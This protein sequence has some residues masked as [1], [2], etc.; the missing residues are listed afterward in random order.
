M[1]KNE[2]RIS[3]IIPTYNRAEILITSLKALEK[4]LNK[5]KDEIIIVDDGSNKEQQELVKKYVLGK[6]VCCY[7]Y[8]K[9]EGPAAARNIAV[10]KAKGD[11][12]IFLN[13]DSIVKDDFI[14]LQINFHQKHKENEALIGRFEELPSLVNTPIMKWLVSE[15]Q[16]HFIY[17]KIRQK[18]LP[19]HYFCTG[20]LSLKKDFVIKNSF[21]FDTDFKVAA[22]ED[23][24]FG[25]RAKKKNLAIY[26]D[27]RVN[28]WHNHK[29]KYQD[30]L[31]RF[32]AHGRGMYTI[33][34]KI[35]KKYLPPLAKNS[36]QTI[37]RL[38]LMISGYPLSKRIIEKWG[39][40]DKRPN[41][42]LMQYLIIGEKIKGWDYEKKSK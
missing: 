21:R 33:S 39:Q 1:E 15:S 29:F 10:S 42:I 19:W 31:N 22:W 27:G 38:M 16:L 11:I 8:K 36:F 34:K 23:I 3:I 2:K 24:E 32:Y 41:N 25:Y 9:N 20:N 35:P 26:F 14:E 7:I 6:K 28:V 17:P 40:V 4:Q 37:A 12:L 30:I 18:V 13:D 5:K